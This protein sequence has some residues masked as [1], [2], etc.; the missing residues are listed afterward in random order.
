[1]PYEH[2]VR[3]AS[4]AAALAAMLLASGCGGSNSDDSDNNPTGNA[5]SPV[6]ATAVERALQS[7]MAV[8]R[9]RSNASTVNGPSS[10][11]LPFI[12]T[13]IDPTQSSG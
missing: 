6:V 2:V 13:L 5:P 3:R 10:A 11:A 4:V 9:S 8:Q 1:M 7:L 12:G